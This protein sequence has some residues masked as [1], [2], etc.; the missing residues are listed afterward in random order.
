MASLASAGGSAPEVTEK[1]LKNT[2]ASEAKAM[3]NMEG[4]DEKGD[5]RVETMANAME[6]LV[7]MIPEGDPRF[8]YASL[9]LGEGVC[10]GYTKEHVH[11]AFLL[12]SQKPADREGDSFNVSKAFRRLTAFADYTT[13]MFDKFFQEPVDMD[14]PDIV[15]AS[16]LM[17]ILIPKETDPATGATVWIMD[18]STWDMSK[19]QDIGAAGTSHRSI[20]RWFFM[21]MVRSMW[22][23]ATTVHGV[24]I[25]EAFGDVGMRDML[26]M[27]GLFK[28][29]ENDMNRMFYGVMP[30]KM[31]SCVLVGTPWWMSAL[32]AFMR[33]FISK[34]MSQRI[35]NLSDA[36]AV[37]E[38]GG[39]SCLPIGFLG[40]TRPYESRYPG[41]AQRHASGQEPG[42]GEDEEVEDI[43]L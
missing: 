29:I 13:E 33:L 24:V 6:A 17:K 28:P 4:K 41:F 3:N 2:M 14:A 23:D 1:D 16:D 20:M 9:H 7:G 27:Q 19:Y 18:M 8:D 5:V 15:A 21:V 36:D 38:M 31:K 35:K 25:V 42:E 37:K 22:D 32:L 10:K 12:W 39:T 11:R 43:E 40:G 26:K 30:F 34:K